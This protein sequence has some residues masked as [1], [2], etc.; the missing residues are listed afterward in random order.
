MNSKA[1]QM[2]EVVWSKLAKFGW[3]TKSVWDSTDIVGDIYKFWG[4]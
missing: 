2:T 1:G 4:Q 3:E